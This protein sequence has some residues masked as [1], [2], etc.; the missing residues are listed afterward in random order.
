MQ[1]AEYTLFEAIGRG[2]PVV[3]V[4]VYEAKRF[5][6][7]IVQRYGTAGEGRPVFIWRGL[8]LYSSGPVPIRPPECLTRLEGLAVAVALAYCVASTSTRRRRVHSHS[9]VPI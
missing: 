8:T 4:S 9:Q 3:M 5:A 7:Q 2:D 1:L 6:K